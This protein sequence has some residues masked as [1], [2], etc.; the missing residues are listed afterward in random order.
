MKNAADKP[1][2]KP[3][4][5]ADVVDFEYFVLQQSANNSAE[6]GQELRHWYQTHRAKLREADPSDRPDLA[7]Q[8]D[9]IALR[10]WLE[11]QRD[12]MPDEFPRPGESWAGFMRL[13]STLVLVVGVLV[14]AGVTSGLL[15]Y[16]G[17]QPV[18]VAM[19]LGI[20]VVFQMG[21]NA[22]SFLLL[23]G[24]GSALL[25]ANA[26][27]GR[28]VGG[29]CFRWVATRLHRHVWS[30]MPA[31]RRMDWESFWQRLSRDH[32][33]SGKY[34][35]WPILNR[36]Q[37]LGV[38]FNIGAVLTF[39]LSVMFRDLAFGW[40]TS[41]EQI[42][43]TLMASWVK[44]MALPWSAWLG[45]GHGYPSLDQI[46]GSRIILREGLAG[47]QNENLTAWWLFLLL[48]LCVYGLVPR[49]VLWGWSG[50]LS[51]SH[52]TSY[53]FQSHS[54]KKLWDGFQTPY[55]KVSQQPF[56]HASVQNENGTQDKV[57]PVNVPSGSSSQTS[58]NGIP[59][60]IMMD[61]DLSDVIEPADLEHLLSPHGWQVI[62]QT[63]FS[64]QTSEESLQTVSQA[65]D[66]QCVLWVQE[67]W[68][69]PIMEKLEQMKQFR[70]AL[71]GHVLLM[72]GLIGK[73]IRDT[74]LTAVRERDFE[75]WNQF[76]KQHLPE[77][78]QLQCLIKA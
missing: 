32:G 43:E 10:A 40:Q 61:A 42:S 28:Q 17:V 44:W 6:A 25:P 74:W 4:S 13:L 39:A 54:A 9:P 22:L 49:L 45:E 63:T 36:I 68:Q 73:P 1:D 34:L 31:E 21:W 72:V 66:V 11:E 50:W 67:A 8:T 71:P 38:A 46:E 26:G 60:V 75:I 65:N 20:L 78:T 59:C 69:P 5:L 12:A 29:F 18:N 2:S 30:H 55:L 15:R 35:A 41:M 3:W 57:T 7:D 51:R 16:D 23:V 76:L 56:E 27:V 70:Q 77:G 52:I 14:G 19:L 62:D 33:S 48:S 37:L 53:P 64:D 58:S 47:L 24:K